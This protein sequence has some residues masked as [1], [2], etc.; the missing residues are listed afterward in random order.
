MNIWLHPPPSHSSHFKKS[1]LHNQA[2]R[3][4]HF[5]SLQISGLMFSCFTSLH[6]QFRFLSLFT[7]VTF[8]YPASSPEGQNCINSCTVGSKEV[9]PPSLSSIFWQ[10]ISLD[11]QRIL[12][13]EKRD[14]YSHDHQYL[15]T[16][17]HRRD[18]NPAADTT[19][20]SIY[21]NDVLWPKQW[22]LVS[23]CLLFVK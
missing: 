1:W 5:L 7:L 20:S 22:Y 23:L 15:A 16:R 2:S 21:L 19:H 14:Y 8:S 3:F 10:I 17:R 9:A 18:N 12:V 6:L 11:Q 13:R 4:S